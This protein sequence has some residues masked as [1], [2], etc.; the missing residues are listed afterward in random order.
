MNNTTTILNREIKAYFN[1]AIAYIFIVV[2]LLM[3]AGLFMTQFFLMSSADMRGFFYM[4]PIILCIFLPAVTMRLWSEDRKGNTLELLLTFPVKT[5]EL[6]LG[7]FFA[8]LAFYIIALFSTLTIPIM[9]AVLGNPDIGSII[10]QYIGS[11]LMGSFFLALGILISGF[12]KDQIVSFILAMV[13]CFAVFLLGMDFTAGSIDG[14][15]PGAGSFFRSSVGMIQHF[16]TFQKGIIDTRDALYFV[17]G[18]VIFLGLNR[19]WLD[20]RMRPKSK[21]TFITACLISVGIFSLTNFIFS[22]MPVGRFDWTSGKIYT[23]SKA[24]HEILGELK[25]PVTVKLFISPQDKMPTE[26][27]TLEREVRDKLDEF[28]V[29]SNGKFGYK[30]FHMEAAN[31]AEENQKDL[32][33][34]IK[35]KGIRPFQVRS[36]EADEVGVKL[37]YAAI[38]VAYK[39]KPEEVIPAITLQ[40]LPGLEYSLLAKIYRLSLDKSPSVAVV[41]P[42]FERQ[43]DPKMRQ[44]LAMFGQNAAEQYREDAYDFVEKLLEYEGY[45]TFRVRL[46]EE[47]PIP[48]DAETGQYLVS[49]LIVLEP[50]NL[51]ERQRFEINKFLVNGGSVFLAVQKYEYGY[52]ASTRGMSVKARDKGPQINSLINEWALGIS[53]DLLMDRQSDMISITG[54]AFPGVMPVSSPVKFPMQLK[55]IEEQMNKNISI[56]SRLSSLLYLWGSALTIDSER[57]NKLDLEKKL[58]F[59]SSRYAWEIPYHGGALTREDIT[60]PASSVLKEYPLAVLVKGQFPDAFKDKEIPDWPKKED[61]LVGTRHAL[62]ETTPNPGKLILIGCSRMFTKELI[63]NGGHAAF[64]LN[65][66]DA[67]TL[68]E[69]LIEVRS[70]Q[71][72][73]RSLRKFSSAVRAGWRMFTTFFVPIILCIIGGI[74]IFMRRRAKWKVQ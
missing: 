11:I 5:H 1:S 61:Q 15:I 19:F 3:S 38:S 26:M 37:I 2:F 50:E 46:T 27:K 30:V 36:I 21:T 29:A 41:A 22:D 42:Y 14:W 18:T 25:S 44:V 6:V 66:I 4:L 17:M 8:S 55:I 73:D 47:E 62:S 59:T 33:E 20:G 51:N 57:L 53:D 67:L 49:T 28:K 10:C 40:D 58:L 32:E 31:V 24:T 45:K 72:V 63:G 54:G 16:D 9:I 71:P 60:S 56:T 7:K 48:K 64:F 39:E 69:K 68:G 23:I 52:E 12:C 34:S 43:I 74:R 70:K 65:S 13:A 35:K